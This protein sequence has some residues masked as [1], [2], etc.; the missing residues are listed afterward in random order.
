MPNFIKNRAI[1][2]TNNIKSFIKAIDNCFAKF[3]NLQPLI[4]N[5]VNQNQGKDRY[6]EI[7]SVINN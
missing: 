1:L 4:K 7:M 3:C 6:N 5:L 2:K